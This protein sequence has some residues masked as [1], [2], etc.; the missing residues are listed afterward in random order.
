MDGNGSI[1]N[2]KARVREHLVSHFA[3]PTP[4][5]HSDVANIAM[6]LSDDAGLEQLRSATKEAKPRSW[7]LF[8]KIAESCTRH[9][10]DYEHAQA[11]AAMPSTLESKTKLELKAEDYARRKRLESSN[12]AN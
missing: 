4:P 7:K 8:V 3:L 2:L 5:D 12:N 9:R 10:A 11:T 6:L 1:M